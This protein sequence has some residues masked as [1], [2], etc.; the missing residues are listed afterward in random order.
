M[1]QMTQCALA[2]SFVGLL[3]GVPGAC[4]YIMRIP[5]RLQP[6]PAFPGRLT[7]Q[8][9]EL[10]IGRTHMAGRRRLLSITNCSDDS[11]P[12][13]ILVALIKGVQNHTGFTIIRAS[14]EE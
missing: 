9:P 8:R 6:W 13:M 5:L 1:Y 11:K 3:A 10:N 7:F 4:P 14:S 2:S 12:Y